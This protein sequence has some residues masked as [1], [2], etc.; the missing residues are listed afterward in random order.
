MDERDHEG[1]EAVVGDVATSMTKL[2]KLTHCLLVPLFPD[3]EVSVF[4]KH[5][6][7]IL[8]VISLSNLNRFSKFFNRLIFE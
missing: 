8:M 1:T 4:R 6:D 2:P 3:L 5:G 7:T